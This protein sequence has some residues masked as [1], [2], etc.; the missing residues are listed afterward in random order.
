MA[1]VVKGVWLAAERE[2][3]EWSAAVERRGWRHRRVG[4]T[5]STFSSNSIFEA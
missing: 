4:G 5:R 1:W 2:V 3:I